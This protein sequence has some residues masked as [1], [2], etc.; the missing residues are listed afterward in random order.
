MIPLLRGSEMKVLHHWMRRVVPDPDP[1]WTYF[2][3]QITGAWNRERNGDGV[4]NNLFF[5]AQPLF[6]CDNVVFYIVETGS[7][8]TTEE[9][10]M[11]ARFDGTC[12]VC[13]G[14]I[15]AG[16]D[17][18]KS[19]GIWVHPACE[20]ATETVTS[21]AQWDVP[22]APTATFRRV[23][24]CGKQVGCDITV[25]QYSGIESDLL[26][27]GYVAVHEVTMRKSITYKGIDARAAIAA[28]QNLL[29]A[30]G[31]TLQIR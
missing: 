14:R 28:E 15:H 22:V 4:K 21:P 2:Q 11:T 6:F 3:C 18:V 24:S 29:K 31:C 5:F 8:D 20:E 30:L 10:E 26:A 19:N 27:A 23:W 25:S 1:G 7:D 12:K 13:G 16:T 9:Q 17:I